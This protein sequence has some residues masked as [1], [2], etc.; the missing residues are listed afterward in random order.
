MVW[1]LPVFFSVMMVAIAIALYFVD[2]KYRNGD[3][4]LALVICAASFLGSQAFVLRLTSRWADR[5]R[6]D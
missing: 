5:Q 3:P 2:P 1:L 6:R 4:L